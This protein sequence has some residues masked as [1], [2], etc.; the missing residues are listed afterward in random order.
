MGTAGGGGGAGPPAAHALPPPPARLR[1]RAYASHAP[2]KRW[3]PM[4]VD[5]TP[6]RFFGATF[7]FDAIIV[8]YAVASRSI[9]CW[10]VFSA[11]RYA[12]S[13]V[14]AKAL[15]YAASSGASADFFLPGGVS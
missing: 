15:L 10:T 6:C 8:W 13:W 1:V 2:S 14:D 12:P 11:A 9:R 5:S 4:R 7:W 3:S